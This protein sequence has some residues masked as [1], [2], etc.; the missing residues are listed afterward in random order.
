LA[1]RH[2]QNGHPLTIRAFSIESIVN[3]INTQLM[4]VPEECNSN[5]YQSTINILCIKLPMDCKGRKREEVKIG[6]KFPDVNPCML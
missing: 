4:N 3:G 1:E 5:H 2:T 6:K